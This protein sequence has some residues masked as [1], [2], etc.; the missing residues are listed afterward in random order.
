MMTALYFVFGDVVSTP[1]RSVF[2]AYLVDGGIS[3]EYPYTSAIALSRLLIT[4]V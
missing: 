1:K 2:W 4:T 3:I